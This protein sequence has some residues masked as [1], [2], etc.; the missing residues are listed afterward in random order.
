MTWFGRARRGAVAL[1]LASVL[2]G[3]MPATESQS[4]ERKEPHFIDGKNQVSQMDFQGAIESFEK[5]VEVNP[6]SAAAHFELG[7]LS[8]E[9]MNDPAEAIYHYSRYLRFSSNPDRMDMTNRIN[10][11]KLELVKTV[12]TIGPLSS[13]AQREMDRVVAENK[14]LLTKVDNLELELAQAKAMGSRLPGAP[15]A[16]IAQTRP[17]EPASSGTLADN[18]PAR[19]PARPVP[20]ASAQTNSHR[21]TAASSRTHVVKPGENPA[22]IARKY[23]LSVAELMAANP[24]VVP[25]RLKAGQSLNLPALPGH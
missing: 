9:K 20:N 2:C 18:P 22:S 24:G 7:W 6:R 8:E 12:P 1:L 3:C 16:M 25:T 23:G 17:A 11:C 19:P 10:R 4:D 13:A 15:G 21:S 14:S 5:A